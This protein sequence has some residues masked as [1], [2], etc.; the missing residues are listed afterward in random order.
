MKSTK[1]GTRRQ[2]ILLAILAGLLILFLVRWSSLGKSPPSPLVTGLR[3]AEDEAPA[4]TTRGARGEEKSLSPEDVPIV[5]KQDLDPAPARRELRSGRNP[6]DFRPPT[7]PPPPTPTPAPPPPP[8]CGDPRFLGPCPPPPPPP[9]PT[10]PAIAF[11]F[12]G[13]FGPKDRPIAVLVLGDQSVNARAGEVVFDRFIVRKVG[14]ESI[15][16]GFVGYAAS[17]VRRLG[18]AP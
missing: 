7:V 9:T 11:K 17:E 4:R 3:T 6:F 5:T 15:D 16:V 18:I 1:L 8:I 10:P 13:T 2:G 12:I 14:Y